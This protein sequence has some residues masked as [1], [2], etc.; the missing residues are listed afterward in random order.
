MRTSVKLVKSSEGEVKTVKFE[1][2]VKLVKSEG[3]ED[4]DVEHDIVWETSVDGDMPHEQH[5][6][7]A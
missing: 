2:E 6:V 4:D 1:G 5:V 3:D 7:C